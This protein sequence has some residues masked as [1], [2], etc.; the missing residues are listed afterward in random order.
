MCHTKTAV[1][2]T[3]PTARAQF[4]HASHA[5][6]LSGIVIQYPTMIRG[7]ASS[8]RTSAALDGKPETYKDH[9]P[10]RTCRLR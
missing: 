6:V 4:N 9:T 3:V 2:Q 7:V 8:A 10:H 1:I 5:A